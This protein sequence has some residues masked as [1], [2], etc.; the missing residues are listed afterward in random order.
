MSCPFMVLY[1]RNYSVGQMAGDS[2][3]FQTAAEGSD[4]EPL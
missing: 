4:K 3:C 2:S 1:G